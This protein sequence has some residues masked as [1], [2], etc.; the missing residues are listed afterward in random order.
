MLM[1]VENS[2]GNAG[3]DRERECVSVPAHMCQD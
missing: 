2:D 3:K 1:P